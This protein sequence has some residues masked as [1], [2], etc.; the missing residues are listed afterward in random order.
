MDVT[1]LCSSLSIAI[2]IS[3]LSQGIASPFLILIT[4]RPVVGHGVS[5]D[6][7]LLETSHA[8]CSQDQKMKMR[9]LVKKMKKTTLRARF[10]VQTMAPEI[11]DAARVD[12]QIRISEET[13]SVLIYTACL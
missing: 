1:Q 4:A 8:D 3:C 7:A 2:E 10:Q 11:I 5:L 12:G 6:I 13:R 9:T